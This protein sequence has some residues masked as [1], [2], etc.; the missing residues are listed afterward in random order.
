MFC[1]NLDALSSRFGDALES[2]P[3]EMAKEQKELMVSF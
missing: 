1:A 2:Q 3:L